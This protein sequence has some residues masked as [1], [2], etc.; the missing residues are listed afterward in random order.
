MTRVLF[1]HLCAV[2]S[3]MAI[4]HLSDEG[5]AVR[6][7]ASL[8]SLKQQLSQH[9]DAV[10]FLSAQLSERPLA[11]LVAELIANYP[12]L[13]I[14]PIV[15]YQ[16]S[17]QASAAMQAG[18]SDY[19]LQ[20]YQPQHLSSVLHRLRV[21][22]Q[23]N[24][25]IIASSWQSQQ[26]LQLAHRT[27]QTDATV[28][29]TGESGTGKEVL[30]SYVHQHSVRRSGPFVAINCAAIP[31]SMLEA[32]LFGHTKGAFTGATQSQAGKFEEAQGGTLF[33][34]EIGE[35]SPALQA[36]L[37]RVLQERQV[38]RLG[39]HRS[40]TLDIRII[41]ATNVDLQQAVNERQFRQDLYYRLDVLP[42]QWPPL[43]ERRDDILPL[44]QHF[45]R[46]YNHGCEQ[47]AALS[48]EAQQ[49]L[50][51]HDWP[52]NIREL[53]NTIQRALVMRHG[54]WITATDLMLMRHFSAPQTEAKQN[55]K[56][57]RKDAE[58]QYI[59]ETLAKFQGRRNLTAEALGMSTRALRYKIAAMREQG[60]DVDAM[61]RQ[62]M[63]AA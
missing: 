42:L 22:N 2:Q 35:M 6:H 37:L 47:T 25:Q 16:Q 28:L 21:V 27:A 31:E 26:V 34:D 8:A 10:V 48:A 9:D 57:S 20:P 19:L 3:S 43:R 33:L 17:I 56:Q 55:L 11:E 29:I 13:S 18:A 1:A 24:E 49:L 40:I 15:D 7:I 59:L 50:L 62:P 52:G 4:K 14:V 63:S 41:A 30:A 36:K 5:V 23:P 45:I 46:K 12:R 53:E 38:E 51:R 58:H 39:S 44:A 61:T 60:I 54:Q 32:V